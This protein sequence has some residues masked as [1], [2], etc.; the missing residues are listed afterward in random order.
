M[1][2]TPSN[3]SHESSDKTGATDKGALVHRV[4]VTKN[5]DGLFELNY[6]YMCPYCG[7]EHTQREADGHD[8]LMDA[9]YY[10]TPCGG[11]TIFMPWVKGRRAIARSAMPV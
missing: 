6:S 7:Q 4:L 9:V 3:L 5:E 11:V 8:P 1:T 2:R 10:S